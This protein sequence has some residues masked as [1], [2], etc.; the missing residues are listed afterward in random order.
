MPPSVPA[1][2][3]TLEKAWFKLMQTM[4]VDFWQEKAAFD[5]SLQALNALL[6]LK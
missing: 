5:S 3:A 4:S 6:R 2:I 1:E